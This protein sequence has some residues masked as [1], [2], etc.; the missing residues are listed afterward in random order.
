VWSLASPKQL[1]TIGCGA[2]FNGNKSQDKTKEKQQKE[3]TNLY[4]KIEELTVER[5]FLKKVLD[6]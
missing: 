3:I 5:D 4:T 6:A 1:Y 2:V